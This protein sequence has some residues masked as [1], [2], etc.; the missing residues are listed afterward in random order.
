MTEALGMQE[1]LELQ[2]LGTLEKSPSK[3]LAEKGRKAALQASKF[4]PKSQALCPG[5]G[6]CE[7]REPGC[8]CHFARTF[9]KQTRL[10]KS[11]SRSERP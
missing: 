1:P 3:Q 11:S 7:E 10:G 4:P 8:V 9:G 5:S 6:P 2:S